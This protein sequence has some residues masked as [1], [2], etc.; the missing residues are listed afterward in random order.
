MKRNAKLI[1]LSGK[2]GSGKDLFYELFNEIVFGYENKKFADKLKQ[3]CSILSGLPIEYFYNRKKYSIYLEN[4][5]MDIRT[6]MQK[7]G[8]E[9]FRQN[10]DENTWAKSLFSDF[11]DSKWIITDVRF[12]NEVNII[13][14]YNGILIRIER[15][16]NEKKDNHASEI[17]LDYYDKWDYKIINDGSIVD[18]KN[19]IRNT[20]KDIFGNEFEYIQKEIEK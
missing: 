20:I 17:S 16:N 18:Y 8:T 15:P 2:K 11:K 14:K 6:M 10:F 5:N 19:K 13:R 9:V 7:V 12:L 3:I 1:G 4:W